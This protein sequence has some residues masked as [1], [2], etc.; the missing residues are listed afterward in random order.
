MCGCDFVCVC[1]CW[2]LGGGGGELCSGLNLDVGDLFYFGKCAD[3]SSPPSVSNG[4][5]NFSLEWH[6]I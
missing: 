3:V 5:K 1:V 6:S 4:N 2:V